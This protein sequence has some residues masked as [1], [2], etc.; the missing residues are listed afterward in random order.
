MNAGPNIY[1][2]DRIRRDIGSALR[3][4]YDVEEP[5]PQSLVALLKDLETRVRD[6]DLARVRDIEC[7]R[8]LAKIDECVAELLRATGRQLRATHA[9]E[10]R[11]ADEASD[12]SATG[13]S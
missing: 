2:W 7:E 6:A 12:F 3:A 10:G 9:L 13:F 5:A 11:S 8:L 1:E 4:D